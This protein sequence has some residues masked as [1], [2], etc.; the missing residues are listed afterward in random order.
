MATMM[1]SATKN[2]PTGDV[3]N[4]ISDL[5]GPSPRSARVPPAAK[6]APISPA[7]NACDSLEGNP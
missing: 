4:P 1:S 3:T 7:T 5:R 6:P 2:P